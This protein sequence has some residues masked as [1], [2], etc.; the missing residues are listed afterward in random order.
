MKN[1]FTIIIILFSISFTFAQE[2]ELSEKEKARRERNIQAGN[3][4]KRFGYKPKIV[5]LS[6]G[7][8]LEFH[9]LDTIV[10]VGS[11]TFDRKNSNLLGYIRLDT[12]R[13][14]ATLRP[15]LTSRWFNPDPLSDEFPSWS[16]YSFVYNNPIRFIDPDGRAPND[17]IVTSESGIILFTLDDGKTAISRTTAKEL[18]LKKTQWFEPLA[19]NYMPLKSISAGGFHSN[20]VKHFT[21]KQIQEFSDED[22]SMFSYR[23]HGS[24]DW[25]EL[26]EGADG[27][28]LVTVDNMIYW[29]DAIGQFPFAVNRVTDKIEDGSTSDEA[30]AETVQTGKKYGEGKPVGGKTD[31]SNTYDN[32][33]ILR[34]ALNGANG[35]D[36]TKPITKAEADKYLN[37]N[38]TN[39]KK[40]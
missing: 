38:S 37:N 30:I 2:E 29:G 32:Y 36:F 26:E 10:K 8:Y 21:S 9:D 17:I 7:K 15:E 18:Y 39:E 28:Y 23:N 14:E 22:R 11:F 13:S 34:G 5:T 31:N 4:F 12:V 24:G 33:F 16:P 1:L 19:D 40:E 25:K 20:K 3:P 35:K 27:Y 6:K